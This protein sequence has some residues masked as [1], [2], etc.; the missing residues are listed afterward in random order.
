MDIRPGEVLEGPQGKSV[1]VVSL[2]GRGGFGQVFEGRLTDATA[3]AIKTVLTAP[4][5]EEELRVLQ[6]EAKHAVGIDHPNVVRVLYV[7]DGN[8]SAGLP[9]YMVMEYVVGGTLRTIIADH[10]KANTKPT[11]DELRAMYMEIANGMEA[12]N[13]RVVHRDLKPENVLFDAA[14]KRLKI[15]DFGLAKLADAAT[16]SETFKGWGTLPY[17][18]PEAFDGG[19][20]TPAMDIYSAGVLFYELATLSWP[21]QPK[22]GDTTPTAWRNAQ[23]LTPPTD[24]RKLRPD[25]PTDLAL[26]IMQMLQK[27]PA[28][29]P[30]SWSEVIQRLTT[31]KSVAGAPDVSALLTKATS[32]F[33]KESEAEVRAR[34]ERERRAERIA[35]LQQ[36]FMEPLHVLRG[37]VDAFNA[38]SS[39]VK[40]DLRR[41]DPW[42]VEVKGHAGA[43]TLLMGSQVIDDVV[44][45][46]VGVARIVGRVHLQLP[47]QPHSAD[48][49]I[50]DRESF[51][52]FNLV[53]HVNRPEEK[54]GNWMQ[55]RFEVNPLTGRVVY[56]R[57][58]GI[59]LAELPRQLSILGALGE[60][61]NERRA[62]DDVWFTALLIQLL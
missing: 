3:V 8:K 11:V 60:Y 52:G 40:L 10:G 14:A 13:A 31:P 61:Q 49:A 44:T 51:G 17:Q 29:R 46:Y 32:T 26:L 42:T 4:L 9:P 6:N 41:V 28:K 55:L 24:I 15:A 59:G 21:V 53:Y 50:R 56:P 47:V 62:L 38:A 36:A 20:N 33:V 58:F 18:A 37:I 57:W 23:L 12:V 54:F 19:P 5:D 30:A 39:L 2:L 16:R 22:P 45:G 43:P 7:N 27:N 48:D 25:L 1:I 35:L 34:E